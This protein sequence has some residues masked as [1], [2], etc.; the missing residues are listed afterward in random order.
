M[1]KY[2]NTLSFAQMY[3]TKVFSHL[4]LSTYEQDDDDDDDFL[5]F[6][7]LFLFFFFCFLLFELSFHFYGFW[8]MWWKSNEKTKQSY[9]VYTTIKTTHSVLQLNWYCELKEDTLS[10]GHWIRNFRW[11]TY[12]FL[13]FLF[14]LSIIIVIILF[15]ARFSLHGW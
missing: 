3:N 13:C 6:L 11:I 8:I 15:W 10:R 7:I 5:F 2:K 4:R 12:Y 14:V 1:L 9:E